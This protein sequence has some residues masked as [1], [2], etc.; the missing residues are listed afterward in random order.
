MQKLIETNMNP[1]FKRPVLSESS[2]EK[3]SEWSV[4]IWNLGERN[5]NGRTYTEELAQR[6]VKEAAKTLANDGHFDECSEYANAR[7][8]AYEPWIENN[9]MW[10]K[11]KF[12]DSEYEDKIIFCLENG[13]PVGVSSVGYGSMDAQGVI[14]AAT[15]E[16]IR[17]FDFVNQ[18][19]N[20]TFV[21][22]EEVQEP[23]EPSTED[24]ES[25]TAEKAENLRRLLKIHHEFHS[26]GEE[27]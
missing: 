18:P 13:I 6:L 20:E 5:L 25:A 11:F 22:K 3:G 15:Y 8:Y 19:A 27:K 26:L 2:G 12:I 1:T 16:L 21:Q 14:D 10:V 23:T 4:P 7:A 9:Q 24:E 17:Y